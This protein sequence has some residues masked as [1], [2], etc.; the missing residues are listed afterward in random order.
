MKKAVIIALMAMTSSAY[1][2]NCDGEKQVLSQP[3]IQGE[4]RL[5]WE[6]QLESCLLKQEKIKE[7]MARLDAEIKAAEERRREEKKEEARRVEEES[8][9]RLAA[10]AA[11]KKIAEAAEKKAAAE[12]ARKARLPG[13]RIGMTADQVIKETSWGKPRS[14]NRHTTAYGTREQWV[15]GYP[16]YLYFT[17]G[18]LTSIQN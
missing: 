13:V 2:F 17:N 10:A 6:R 7:D 12:I 14:I 11:D 5:I 16:N 1:A 9:S 3:N 8:A 4:T 18:I 15:Y